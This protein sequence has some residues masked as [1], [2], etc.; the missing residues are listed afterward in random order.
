MD[1]SKARAPQR[2]TTDGKRKLSP[3]FANAEEIVFAVHEIPNLV[4]LKRLKLKDGVQERLHPQLTAH[5][6]DPAFS[7][8]GRY[9]CF[10]LSSTSPQLV[11]VIQDLKQKTE[12]VFRPRDSRATV[13]SPSIAPDNRRVVFS[14]SDLDGHMIASVDLKG[15]DF[16]PL[17][18]SAGMNSS[19]AFAP[20]GKR[21]A[22][23]SSRQGD[24][25]IY[26]MN[27][28]GSALTRLTNSPGL[29][30]RPRWSPD[31]KR[32]SFTSNRDGKYAIYV[33]K[34]DGSGLRRISNHAGN[35]DYATWHPEGTKL[36]CVSDRD[37][38]SNLY[39][40]EI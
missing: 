28:D 35:D 40:T 21:I 4:T 25:E 37:G 32:L 26:T 29:D 7:L 17:A 36:L 23:S 13:R 38:G 9:H 19:P 8:D 3:V 11:L 16:K 6:F 10:V 34:A 14:L 30:I 5:Q 20:D 2:I 27:A 24:Y 22:F 39:L 1:S 15:Q 31:S 33:M 12:V 18:I